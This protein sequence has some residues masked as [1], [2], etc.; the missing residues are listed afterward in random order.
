MSINFVSIHSSAAK[1]RKKSIKT[2]SNEQF[3]QEN[4]EKLKTAL[5]F[6]GFN[7]RDAGFL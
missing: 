1:N 6:Q 2:L 7:F 4:F 5:L 3:F